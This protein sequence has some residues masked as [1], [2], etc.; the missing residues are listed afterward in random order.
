MP[1][2]ATRSAPAC[3]RAGALVFFLTSGLAAQSAT[4]VRADRPPVIDGRE[5]DPVWASIAP[6]RTFRQ[7]DPGEDRPPTFETEFRVAFDD[8]NLYVLVRAYDPHPDSIV[9]LLSRRDVKTNSDQ[10]GIIVDGFHDRRNANQFAVNPAGVKRDAAHH[11]DIVEDFSWDG[12]WDVGVNIDDKGWIAEFRIPLSQLRFAIREGQTF[13]LIVAREIARL[14]ERV[15]WPVFRRST[16]RVVS[17]AGTVT[18]LRLPAARRVEILPYAVARSVPDLTAP[19]RANKT[20]FSAGLDAKAGIG[21]NLTLD[22]TIN[23]DFGQVESDPSILNL[24]A[25]EVRFD[26]RRTFFQEGIGLFRCGSPCDGPFYTR[27]I[28][29]TPQL[30]T[31]AAD[32]A[33]TTILG[34]AKLS[35]RLPNGYTLAVLDAVTNEMHGAAG[36]VIEPQTNY[37]VM[38]GGH[39][40]RDGARSMGIL[41]LDTRRRLDATTEPF[42]R[43]SATSFI[44]NFVTRFANNQYEFMAYA[45]QSYVT[46][47]QAAIAATQRNSVHLFQRPDHEDEE[48]DPTRTSLT[49]GAFGGSV[50]KLFGAVKFETFVRRSTP[51]QEM[52][53]LGLV[54]NV[55][56]MHIRQTVS[57]Q[58]RAPSSW[59]RSSFSQV[60]GETHFTVGGMPYARSVNLHASASLKNNV[61]G[62]ITSSITDIGA[63][64]C[65]SCARGGPALRQSPKYTIRGDISGDARRQFVPSATLIV[66][67]SDEGRSGFTE[68]NAGGSVRVGSR[69]S[70]SLAL[71]Y[72]L[73]VN[74]QQWVGNFG[75]ALSDT[76][77]YTFAHLDQRTLAMVA[78]VNWTATPDLSFQFYGQPFISTGAYSRWRELASPRAED[79]DARFRSYGSGA[80]PQGF[81]VKQFNSNA[82]VRWEFRPASVL[83]LVWQ[84]GRAQNN[85]N[86]G[87]FEASRDIN[88]LFAT[89]PQNTLLLKLSYWFNP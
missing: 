38:R 70:T 76:T 81:N 44:S 16:N 48:Y 24:S 29:R 18:G 10:I 77:H 82:V 84:Q 11:S 12:V 89:T 15:A 74:D 50:K 79:Y 27:R 64:N 54:P 25:F 33:F 14:S 52:N 80:T 58:Q 83:F 43:R 5:N 49:G 3:I 37:F 61:G 35:G 22:A 1:S 73:G 23:P 31:S 46:G 13:G 65:V 36:N 63:V 30:R 57:Y 8:R 75:A 53:D 39:E 71:A 21:S 67:R 19:G 55:N 28:G 85:V 56:D 6:T 62:A 88:D 9:R 72:N 69:F 41:L 20:E 60:S 42:L 4:A 51:G 45:G 34:A 66:G 26:E 59:F 86:A 87:T 40:S 32:P 47:S 17:Q 68:G 78:R 2:L 7:Y